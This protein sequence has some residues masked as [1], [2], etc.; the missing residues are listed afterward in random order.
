MSNLTQMLETNEEYR[1]LY[2]NYKVMVEH[3][4]IPKNLLNNLT[5]NT[6]RQLQ[7]LYYETQK[8][9]QNRKRKILQKR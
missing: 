2:I 8:N 7:R 9:Y 1:T 5:I 4:P 6:A 3:R